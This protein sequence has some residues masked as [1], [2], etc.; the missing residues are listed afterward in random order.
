MVGIGYDRAHEKDRGRQADA[1]REMPA[2]GWK[3][4]LIRTFKEVGDDRIT[5]IAAGVTY[6]LL[7]ALFPT[8]SVM[9]SLYGLIADPSSV[10]D[11]LEALSGVI[12]AGGL[13]IIDEQLGRIASA[14][15]PTLSLALLVSLGLALW[16]ASAGVKTLFEAMNIVYDEREKRNFFVLNGIALGFTLLGVIGALVIIAVVIALPVILQFVFLGTGVEWL[17]RIAG[18]AVLIVTLL[19]GIAVL[20]RFGP[21]RRQAKWRWLTPG[22]LLAVFLITLVSA[23]FSWYAASFGHYDETYGSL[24]ALIAFLFWVWISVNAV[25]VGAELNSELEH[26]TARDST[27]GADAPMGQRHA[28]M[29][30]TLGAASGKQEEQ[31]PRIGKSQDW[32]Q[33]FEAGRRDI[34]AHEHRRRHMP[35]RYA[36]PAALAMGWFRR[37]KSS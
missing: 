30:D 21:S 31:D 27:I 14:D 13:N 23:L 37:R 32:V 11:H 22:A 5:L 20:Y 24:G 25:L 35:L 2:R 15:A 18:Y 12:P 26:Q 1:P 16:S 28:V 33:G 17:A 4:V 19:T 7:L 3:D 8:I 9:V 36:L 10:R 34:A 6:F 29:A